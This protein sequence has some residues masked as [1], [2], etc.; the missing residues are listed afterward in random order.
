MTSKTALLAVLFTGVLIFGG[1]QLAY[2]AQLSINVN[3]ETNSS[4]FE[5]KY[6]K[7]VVIEY[8]DGGEIAQLLRVKQKILFSSRQIH[9]IQELQIYKKDLIKNYHQM[10]LKPK[11]TIW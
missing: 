9:L 10:T 5:M 1:S 4:P 7:S 8:E 11:L 2:G 3:P 6:Q